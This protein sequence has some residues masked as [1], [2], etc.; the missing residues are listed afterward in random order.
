MTA[1]VELGNGSLRNEWGQASLQFS[2]GGQLAVTQ[3][4]RFHWTCAREVWQVTNRVPNSQPLHQ[5]DFALVETNVLKIPGMME[6]ATTFPDGKNSAHILT[7]GK[8][9]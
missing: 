5:A 2:Q 4:V 7:Q 1:R 8:K 3:N 6:P 9:S